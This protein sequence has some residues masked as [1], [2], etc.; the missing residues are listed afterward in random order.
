MKIIKPRKLSLIHRTYQIDGSDRLVVKPMVFFNLFKPRMLYEEREGWAL[1]QRCFGG[2]EVLDAGM[3]KANPE[4]LLVGNAY[5]PRDERVEAIETTLGLGPI[6]KKLAISGHSIW[7]KGFFGRRASAVHPFDTMPI[8][9][10]NAYGGSQSSENPVGVGALGRGHREETLVALPNIRYP[11][12]LSLKYGSRL[13]AA[14]YAPIPAQWRPRAQYAEMFD[15]QYIETDFPAMPGN[16]DFRVYNAAPVDQQFERLSGDETYTLKNLHRTSPI[17]GSALP[18]IRPRV[19][20]E[21]DTGFTEPDLT[22]ETVWFLPEVDMGVLIYQGEIETTP[23]DALTAVSDLL[24]AYEWGEDLPR[25]RAFYEN[26]I[27]IRRDPI[28]ALGSSFNEA[29]L[30]PVL[31][32]AELAARD[33]ARQEELAALRKAREKDWSDFKT[34][35]RSRTDEELPE[36]AQL[37]DIDEDLVVT[38]SERQRGDFD[39]TAMLAATDRKVIQSQKQLSALNEEH[40]GKASSAPEPI[41]DEKVLEISMERARRR[42]MPGAEASDTTNIEIDEKVD[43]EAFHR[44]AL[45]AL[46]AAVTPHP[47]SERKKHLASGQLKIFLLELIDQNE[48]LTY[49]DFTG[50][51]CVGL[52]LSG[53][54]LSG[55][56]FESANLSGT[57]FKGSSLRGCSFLSADLNA[58]RFD[59]ADL[60]DAN[61]SRSVGRETSFIETVLTGAIMFNEADLIA[62]DFSRC[63]MDGCV[64][65]QVKLLDCIFQ[66]ARISN[67]TFLNTSLSGSQFQRVSV[68]KTSLTSCRM[69]HSLW[70][71]AVLSQ[72]SILGTALH[73]SRFEGIQFSKCSLSNQST[74]TGSAFVDCNFED[75]GLRGLVATAVTLDKTTFLRCDLGEVYFPYASALSASIEDSLAMDANLRYSN[76]S[77][78]RFVQSSLSNTCLDDCNL[79][80]TDF[81]ATD[82][83]T[84][85]FLDS[86]FEMALKRAKFA[87]GT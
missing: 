18:N 85:S 81:L 1:A 23:Q 56:I 74:A 78:S 47:L 50:I 11:E 3:P 61:F 26:E 39:I 80:G 71:D 84:A 86:N 65:L 57:N 79:M 73:F 49:R 37:S 43:R 13:R 66:D 54:D 51:D 70:Q 69:T 5:A 36:S 76:L 60:N 14:S 55:S 58:T 40:A 2:N 52:D 45:T 53:R 62:A 48:N 7:L 28:D 25:G 77:G 68:Q 83:L 22:L 6:E 64:F 44:M 12:E 59:E 32:Q 31:A 41:S 17:I 75:T 27:N 38:P 63:R 20:L 35:Y 82:V 24:I 46:R 42:R 15:L 33:N 72:T 4:M 29:S 30:S 8:S 21:V 87:Y 9:W 10:E 16:L 34:D 67:T 19:V